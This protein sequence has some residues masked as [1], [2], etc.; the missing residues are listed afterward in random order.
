MLD[1]MIVGDEVSRQIALQLL[2]RFQPQMLDGIRLKQMEVFPTQKDAYDALVKAYKTN[3]ELAPLSAGAYMP[4][5]QRMIISLKNELD[6][7]GKG[8]VFY[9]ELAHA[10]EHKYVD[11]PAWQA[12]YEKE[13]KGLPKI[14]NHNEAFGWA[15]D[16]YMT[17]GD[18]FRALKPLTT[19][20]LQTFG[21]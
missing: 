8:R 5:E 16:G 7:D 21:F 11:D 19:K 9:H 15:M 1:E 10:L 12:A 13:W 18:K 14:P 6:P 20:A 3:P 17:G 2:Q 4:N